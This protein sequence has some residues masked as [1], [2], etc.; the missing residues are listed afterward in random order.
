M[1]ASAPD[2]AGTPQLSMRTL[3][4]VQPLPTIRALVTIASS[5]RIMGI[6]A[7]LVLAFAAAWAG[8]VAGRDYVG[9]TSWQFTPLTALYSGAALSAL[10]GSFW[11]AAIARGLASVVCVLATFDTGAQPG[12][13]P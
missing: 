6:L 5:V 4:Y 13:Q 10:V 2:G 12:R 7:A 11:L 8:L 1:T 9:Q 3:S